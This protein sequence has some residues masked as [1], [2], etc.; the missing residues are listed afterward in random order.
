MPKDTPLG[1]TVTW[2]DMVRLLDA[3]A[4]ARATDHHPDL[5]KLP[6]IIRVLEHSEHLEITP[7]MTPE[8]LE[9]TFEAV[10]YVDLPL[11][12]EDIEIQPEAIFLLIGNNPRITIQPEEI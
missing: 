12:L 3:A 6:I 8:D 10:A 9:I 7:G 2:E 5:P 4:V 11:D 1:E